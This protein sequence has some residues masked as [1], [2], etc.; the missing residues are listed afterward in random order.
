MAIRCLKLEHKNDG[1]NKYRDEFNRIV[2]DKM[3]EEGFDTNEEVELSDEQLERNDEVYKA[4]F[5]MCKTLTNV[6]DLEWDMEFIGDI[7]EYAAE[8]LAQC[9]HKVW[10]PSVITEK[11]GSRH[12]ENYYEPEE[13][14]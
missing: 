12:I 8:T 10:F 2:H 5:Q 9:G 14:K 7:A 6:P 13:E 4:V 1:L 3:T 11:D